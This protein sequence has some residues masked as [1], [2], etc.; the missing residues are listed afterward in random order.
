MTGLNLWQTNNKIVVDDKKKKKY[1][2][3]K[4]SFPPKAWDGAFF[5]SSVIFTRLKSKRALSETKNLIKQR[6]SQPQNK[7]K[8]YKK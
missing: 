2:N 3:S 7:A 5:V 1:L 8:I 4:G 6:I